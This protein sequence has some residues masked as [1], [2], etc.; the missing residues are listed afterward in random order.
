MLF[1]NVSD[2]QRQIRYTKKAIFKD[3]GDVVAKGLWEDFEILVK[4]TEQYTGTAAASWNM[5]LGEDTSVREQAKRT[6]NTALHR[7]H[8]AATSI[9]FTHNRGKLDNLSTEYTIKDIVVSNHAKSAERAEH[10]PLRTV[11]QPAGALADFEQ[12]VAARVF[13]LNENYNL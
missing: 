9:A 8:G 12:A 6:S 11:N 4:S 2:I 10:G 1:L 5:S 3:V 13:I 7:G